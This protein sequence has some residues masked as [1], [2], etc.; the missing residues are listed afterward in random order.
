MEEYRTFEYGPMNLPEFRVLFSHF[1]AFM[2][3]KLRSPEVF[4]WPGAWMAGEKA[5]DSVAELFNRHQALFVDKEE[6]DS[7]FPR[8][9]PDKN[10]ALVQRMFQAFYSTNVTYDLADQWIMKPGPFTYDF[11]SWLSRSMSASDLKTFADRQFYQV[12]GV[13]PDDVELVE[14]VLKLQERTAG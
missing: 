1:L 7:V 2:Q 14:D 3:D 6:D 9:H 10:E 13:K 5:R 12:F 11:F 4:C 8:L